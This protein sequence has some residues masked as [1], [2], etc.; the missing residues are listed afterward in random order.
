MLL[1]ILCIVLLLLIIKYNRYEGFQE[2]QEFQEFQKVKVK[3][4]VKVKEIKPIPHPR[5]RLKKTGLICYYGGAFRDGGN[6][7]SLQ[8]TDIGYNG[9]YYATQT[10]LKLTEV[11]N[12][13]GYKVDT[14]INTY[15]STYEKELTKWYNVYDIIFNT[16]NKKINSTDGRDKLIRSSINNIKNLTPNDY[17]FI[18]FIRIDLFLKPDFFKILDINSDKINFIANNYDTNSCITHNT[19]KDPVVVDLFLFVPKKYFYILDEKFKLSHDSWSYYKKT[20]KLNDTDLGFMT[21]DVFDSN[22]YRDIN[23]YYLMVS[24]KENLKV[25]NTITANTYEKNQYHKKCDSYKENNEK[26]LNNPARVYYT[27]YKKFYINDKSIL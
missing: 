1:I 7:S 20:Y 23:N 10:H 22:S 12:K 18:L 24:R 2:I 15:H 5:D 21:N 11:L 14:I 13:K 6:T 27:K 9:Q 26:H 4:K 8:D 19:Y 17:D 3:V 16:L 25:H